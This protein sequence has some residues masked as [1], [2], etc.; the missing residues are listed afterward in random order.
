MPGKLLSKDSVRIKQRGL[1]E[2]SRVNKPTS[3][4]VKAADCCGEVKGHDSI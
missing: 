4:F 3:L 1:Q 2:K